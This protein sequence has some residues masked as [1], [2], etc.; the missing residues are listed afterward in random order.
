MQSLISLVLLLF[1]TSAVVVVDFHKDN[2]PTQIA[3]QVCIGLL[4]EML[5]EERGGVRMRP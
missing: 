5:Y 1:P 4:A 2:Y 3:A